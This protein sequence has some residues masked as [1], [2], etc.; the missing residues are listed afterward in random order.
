VPGTVVRGP[1]DSGNAE[2]V[3]GITPHETGRHAW[4]GVRVT[5]R[6]AGRKHVVMYHDGF[7]LCTP[8]VESCY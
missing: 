7:L 8:R 3:F 4:S 5:Y 1:S 2:L 6:V